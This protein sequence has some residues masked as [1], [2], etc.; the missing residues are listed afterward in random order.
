LDPESLMF[1][2]GVARNRVDVGDLQGGKANA[3]VKHE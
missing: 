2:F 3:S 1:Q